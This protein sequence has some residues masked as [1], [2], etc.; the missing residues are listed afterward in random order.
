MKIGTFLGNALVRCWKFKY[1]H[2][3]IRLMDINCIGYMALVGFLVIFFHKTVSRWPLYVF[4]H[5][6]IVIGILEIIRLGEKYPNMK[7]LWFIRTFYPIALLLYGWRELDALLPIF[8]GS[9][10]ATDLII[11]WDKL[12]F[13]VHPTVWIQQFYQPWLDELMNFFYAGYYALFLLVPL[14]FFVRQ[15]KQE[16]FAVLSVVTLSYFSNY[17]LFFLMPVVSPQESSLLQALQIK[18]HGGFLIAEFNR[19]V[20]ASGSSLGASFPSSHVSGALVWVLIAWRYSRKLGYI[21]APVALGIGIAT[22]YLGLHHAI[23][24]I[25]GYIWGTFCYFIALKLIK[26]RRED[27]L[28]V[29]PK[30]VDSS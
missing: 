11:R 5:I 28:V 15:K 22:V 17:F 4:I 6:V 9:Y 13:G 2:L 25:C 21:F 26:Q 23:D 14:Y 29:S 24:P 18:Q 20:Q 1:S 19:T 16:T 8:F 10:W 30:P 12:I 3:K 7:I 27:P